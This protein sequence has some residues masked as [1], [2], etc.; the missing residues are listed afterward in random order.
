M[1]YEIRILFIDKSKD[2]LNI[3]LSKLLYNTH[4]YDSYIC[5]HL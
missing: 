4:L 2:L 1:V 3:I 5:F